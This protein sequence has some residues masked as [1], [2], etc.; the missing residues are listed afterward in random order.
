[1]NI[2]IQKQ[3]LVAALAKTQSVS[4]A[5]S[6]LPIL[7]TV[8]IQAT[9]GKTQF[10]GTD[11]DIAIQCWADA[12]ATAKGEVALP[13]RRLYD[14]ARVLVEGDVSIEVDQKHCATIR[15]GPSLF[16]LMGMAPTEFP[17]LPVLSKE[18]PSITVPQAV[19]RSMLQAVEHAISVDET[20]FV[21]CGVLFSVEKDKLQAVATDGRRLAVKDETAPENVQRSTSNIQLSTILPSSLVSHLLR[22]LGDTADVTISLSP[23]HVQFQLFGGTCITSKLIEG[24][25]P[26]WKQVL[27]SESKHDIAVNREAIT[28][29]LRRVSLMINEKINSVNLVFAKNEL[30]ISANSP[31][32]GGACES[33]AVKFTAPKPLSIAFNPQYLIE[34]IHGATADDVTLH[35][36][37]ELSPLRVT[38]ADGYSAVVMPMRM[39]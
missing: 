7:S 8:L 35:L 24:V 3:S 14:I 1:M 10:T 9:D 31:D 28:T 16:K 26:N 12:N 6:T 39:S 20:R 2:T 38:A 18:C 33:L 32:V 29:V 4:S 11:L 23:S 27:P 13:S 15:S 30:T 25:F 34:A 21:L 19:L 22:E 5:R 17:T 36:V 37:D